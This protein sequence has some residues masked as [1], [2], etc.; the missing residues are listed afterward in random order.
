M[1]A[2]L[3]SLRE[4]Q[5]SESF[6]Q[7]FRLTS[8]GGETVDWLGGVFYYT[9]DFDRGDGGNSPFFVY[10][11]LS[12]HPV[13]SAVNQQVLGTPFPLPI[14]T[15]G[16]LGFL[17]SNQ[18][19]DYIGVYGQATWNITDTFNITGGLR[20]QEEEKD[21]NIQQWT[22]DPSPSVISLLLSPAAASS[23]D[24]NRKTDE[25]TWSV[26]PQWFVTEDTMLYGT[27]AH[28]FKSGGFNTG[29]GRLRIENREFDDENIMH[30]ELGA[31]TE[32]W[33]GRAR[34][35]ASVF[36][37]EYDD[38]QD[39]A[40]VGSQFTVG[41][42]EKAELKGFELEGT[43]LL[44]ESLT[45][46]FAISY[47]DF[48]YD[49]NTAGQCYPGRTPD[50]PTDPAACDLSGE[51]PVNAPEWKTHVGL[52][53]ERPV[54]WGEA[55][56]RFDWSWTSEYN[57]SFS[58]DP[59][60]EQDAYSWVNLRVGTRWEAYELVAWVDNATDETVVNF[61][62]VVNLY[63]GDNSYQSFLQ[64]PRSYGVTFRVNY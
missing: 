5:E 61:D 41:N 53:Y 17:D 51:N 12:D 33:E 44:S 10:D 52:L 58:A 49:K 3:L 39:A 26:S 8:A 64:A 2:P 19:T 4:T 27:A 24:L 34:L 18:D 25:V 46:D 16:Q 32:L 1:M 37:T 50:S 29:F 62:A 42:A 28:A 22:N 30:Y 45:A 15:Q 54:S 57:T 31:K 40:F 59:R 36:L 6:Q 13:V 23:D 48:T 11:E 35:S 20:W 63:A 43:V 9:N 38:Y 7:E 56:A 21:A 14:A 55:Y 47:A 60:L